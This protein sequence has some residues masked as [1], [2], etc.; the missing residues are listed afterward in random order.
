MEG[1]KCTKVGANT[2][3]SHFAGA[4]TDVWT[5]WKCKFSYTIS[6][7]KMVGSRVGGGGGCKNRTSGFFFFPATPNG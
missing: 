4:E 3:R 5:Q 2:R 1:G 6:K 7:W